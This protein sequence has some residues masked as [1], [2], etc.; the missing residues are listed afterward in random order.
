MTSLSFPSSPYLYLNFLDAD[1]VSDLPDKPSCLVSQ[2]YPRSA[3]YVRTA[4]CMLIPKD[5]KAFLSCLFIS[6]SYLGSAGSVRTADCMLTPVK[7]FL[8]CLSVSRSHLSCR[9]F[10]Q[11][12][13]SR[14]N[15]QSWKTFLS[16]LSVSQSYLG[17]AGSVK[18]QIAWL[19]L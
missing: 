18:Q 11:G 7:P 8:S 1:S 16:C 17:A 6:Q 3:G 9:R 15:P 2:Y 13:H 10:L 14:P 4:D 5:W 19:V 12:P